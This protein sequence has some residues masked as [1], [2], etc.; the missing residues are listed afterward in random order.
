MNISSIDWVRLS[1]N[2]PD[3]ATLSSLSRRITLVPLLLARLRFSSIL[4]STLTPCKSDFCVLYPIAPRGIRGVNDSVFHAYG[5]RRVKLHRG[6]RRL[7]LLDN[8]LF[9]PH[10]TIHLLSISA[11]CGSPSRPRVVFD[12]KLV[13]LLDRSGAILVSGLPFSRRLYAL[14]GSPSSIDHASLAVRPP[15]LAS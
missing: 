15:T 4:A 6:K 1:Y 5:V 11:H 9:V 3:P 12:H 14:A 8:V 7:P 10:A 13:F 2:V